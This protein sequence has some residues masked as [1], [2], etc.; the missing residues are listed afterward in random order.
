MKRLLFCVGILALAA[1]CA[2]DMDTMSVQQT[3]EKGIVFTTGDD[4]VITRGEYQ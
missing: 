2:E 3:N 4:A 1:S